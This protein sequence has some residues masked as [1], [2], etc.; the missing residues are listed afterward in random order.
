MA[1]VGTSTRFGVEGGGAGLEVAGALLGA[2]FTLGLFFGISRFEGDATDDSPAEIVRL[3]SLSIPM[4]TPP[5]RPEE[6]PEVATTD[7]PFAGIEVGE[8]ESDVKIAVVPPDLDQFMPAAAA[9]PVAAVKVSQLYTEFKPKMDIG[10]DFGRIFQQWEVDQKITV[11][12]R[13]NPVIPA[14]VRRGADVLRVVLIMVVNEKGLPGSIRILESSGNAD[15]DNII[16]GE[17][18]DSWVFTPAIRKGRKVKCLIQ[19]AVRVNWSG[20]ASPF[21]T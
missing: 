15:F 19:Q 16:V 8:S 13:P 4:E 1:T 7:S 14:A 20:N 12:S 3:R 2:L 21:E 11:L 6:V 18:A 10:A 17:V 9:A 5:P